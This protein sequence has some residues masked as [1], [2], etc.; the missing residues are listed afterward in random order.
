MNKM[1]RAWKLCK[2]IQW[3]DMLTSL[4]YSLLA[5]RNASHKDKDTEN[6]LR[7]LQAQ[8][9]EMRDILDE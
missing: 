2:Q 9:R 3:R 4:D 7:D 8:I 6:E 1:H 5:V